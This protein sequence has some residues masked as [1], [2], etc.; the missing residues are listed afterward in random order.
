MRAAGEQ[1]VAGLSQSRVAITTWFSGS[2]IF[3]YGAV[4]RET[5]IPDGAPLEVVIAVTGPSKP[6]VVRRKEREFGIWMNGPG[7]HVDAAP[8]F[9]AVATT[10]PFRDV[11][12]WTE[13]LRHRVGLDQVIRLIDAPLWAE[14]SREE[15]LDAVVRL[16]RA[17]GVYFEMIGGVSIAEQ[18]LFQ[19]RIEL[20]AEIVE[21]DY[22]A[23]IFLT[24]DR[25]VVD[26][27]ETS[28]T[29]RK[30][31][32]EYWVDRMA[33][34]FSALY[35]ILSVVVALFAGWAASALFRLAFP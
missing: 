5:P 18:T 3:I 12:S 15:Y 1:V 4:K 32:L 31:G 24:R 8:S 7:L 17:K 10:G 20:P 29:V 26:H 21:G 23:R 14:E 9:Y 11:L 34:D 27:F 2:E 28:I 22:T 33:S 35:G 25:E 16:R 19:T 30:V 6:V 13:D